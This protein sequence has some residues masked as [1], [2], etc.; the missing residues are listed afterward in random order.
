MSDYFY[1]FKRFKKYSGLNLSEKREAQLKARIT[2]QYHVVEKGMTLPK[3]RL[4]YGVGVI[5]QLLSNL[6]KFDK[7]NYEKNCTEYKSAVATLQS[8]VDYHLVKEYNV[9]WLIPKL[10]KF[11][12]KKDSIG[13]IIEYTREEIEEK[14]KDRFSVFSQSRH[15]VR[16]YSDTPINPQ[17]IKNAVKVAQKSPSVCNRQSS[18]V[19]YTFEKEII[20]K[21]LSYQSGNRGFG[22]SANCLLVVTSDIRSFNGRNERNQSFIDGGIFTMSLLYGL[23]EE[24]L[25]ACPLNWSTTA[26]RDLEIKKHLNIPEYENIIL[27]ISVGNLPDKINIAKSNR[28]G[29]EEIYKELRFR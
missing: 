21:A 27:M 3:T 8:Y 23:H 28:L 2:A 20:K 7:Y 18:R 4:G 6:E 24:M 14:S 1:D 29:T 9:D 16:H 19:Y 22:S 17:K 26:K 25:G 11:Q 5:N 15:S 10:D 12:M 13:G